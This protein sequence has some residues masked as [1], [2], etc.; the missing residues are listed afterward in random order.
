MGYT[1]DL[2]EEKV[3][4]GFIMRKLSVYSEKVL[5][6]ILIDGRKYNLGLFF[7]FIIQAG[8][9][10]QVVQLHMTNWSP[11]GSCSHLA[12]ITSVINE[13]SAIQRRSGNHPVVVHCRYSVVQ[14]T[15]VN[16]TGVDYCGMWLSVHW[17]VESL[18]RTVVP[19]LFGT[20][21]PLPSLAAQQL[22]NLH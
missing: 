8:S 16:N 4:E 14:W 9:A 2:M 17:N 10:H 11:D 18:S 3:M 21:S 7:Y 20:S 13:M 6:K 5:R 15:A 19:S 22:S 12:T 1:V